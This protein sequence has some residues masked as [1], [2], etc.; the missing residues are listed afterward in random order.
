[1]SRFTIPLAALLG[2]VLGA[3]A[4]L[5]GSGHFAPA[6]DQARIE[7]VVHDYLLAHPEVLPD[8]M[9]ALRDKQ[10]A[11]TIA[12]NHAAI[13]EPFGS[14][15][16]GSAHPDLT[17]VEYY[18]YNCGYCRASL[19]AIAQLLAS[20]PKLR[21]VFREFPVLADSS[22]SAARMSLAAAE[23][24]KFKPFHDSLY[25]GGPVTDQ[26]IAAAAKIAGVDT[27]KAAAFAPKADAEIAA[28]MGIARQLGL[29]GTPSWVIGN[30]VVSSALPLEDLQNLV[31]K[32]R[33]K[34]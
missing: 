34:G 25:A 27:V 21:I 5:W 33:A 18:D 14:A 23:Q 7:Q 26:S 19:P 32:A 31:A 12:D 28:N 20:D 1:M 24:G 22:A 8:A 6:G 11:K 9:D 4:M 17:I 2:A 10:H 3:G 15:W 16:A 29:T 30:H 13:L